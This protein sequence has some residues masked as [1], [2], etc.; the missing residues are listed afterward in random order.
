MT[1]EALRLEKL[2]AGK[3][4]NAYTLRNQPNSNRVSF[5]KKVIKKTKPENI[6]EVGCNLGANLRPISKIVPAR[7]LYGVDIN[8]F[9]LETLRKDFPGINAVWSQA[10][11]LPF[12]SGYFDMTFTAGVLIHQPE[13]TLKRVMGEVVRCSGRWVLCL[14]YF[15]TD[16]QEVFY[17]GNKGALFKRDYGTLYRRWFSE[18]KLRQTGF[19]SKKEG[20][21]DITFWLF[22]KKKRS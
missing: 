3:F 15:S 14:E 21:D 8:Q 17:R 9:A 4:G 5:W 18:L 22:E 19:L 2:W 11:E 12:R 6:L 1:K 7:G 20:W 10:R 13:E 16:T